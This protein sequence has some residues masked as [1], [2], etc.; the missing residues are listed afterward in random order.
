MIDSYIA[1]DL[2]TTGLEAK[3]E[4]II[5]IAALKVRE[6]VVRERL[7]TLINPRR[8]LGERITELT[9]LTDEML[10]NAPVIEDVIGEVIDFC[11]DLPLLGHHII[12]DYGFLKRAAVNSQLTFEKEGIDTLTLCRTFMPSDCKRNLGSA[13]TFY[14]I[15]PSAAHRAEAD[16]EAAHQLYQK[17]KELHS[18][19]RPELFTAKTLIYKVKREQPAT[20]RQKDY[21]RDLVKCH[22]IDIT[23]Q[24]DSM[25]RSEVSRMID[26]IISQ[27]GRM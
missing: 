3:L 26:T 10:T 6:G 22:R 16:A 4:K 1:I 25:S 12:F 21:L 14:E 7:V 8:K 15:H 24:I 5:E 27:Y 19:D 13:C 18:G 23:V 17:L 11:E 2:E 20:K 9:G